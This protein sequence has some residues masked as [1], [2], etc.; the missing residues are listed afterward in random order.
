[1]RSVRPGG[2]TRGWAQSQHRHSGHRLDVAGILLS[3]VTGD[4]NKG[5]KTSL[6]GS[7]HGWHILGKLGEEN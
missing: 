3:L 2:F 6:Q 1:M 7:G 4:A 5:I